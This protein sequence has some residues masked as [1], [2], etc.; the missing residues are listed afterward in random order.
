MKTGE[1]HV[2]GVNVRSW[3]TWQGVF[4]NLFL[5]YSAKADKYY[6]KGD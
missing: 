2:D 5:H 3:F 4:D 6:E 1:Q